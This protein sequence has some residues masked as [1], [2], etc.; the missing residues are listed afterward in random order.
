MTTTYAT[1]P[2]IFAGIDTPFRRVAESRTNLRLPAGLSVVSADG[3]WSI[4][5]D[6]FYE[7]FP[8]RLKDRAPRLMKDETG[9]FDWRI[10]GQSIFPDFLR[11]TFSAFE[12]VDGCTQMDAR[13][14]DLDAEGIDKEIA[15][16]NAIA[17]FYGSPDLE[18]REWVFRI[19]NEHLSEMQA[20]APGRFYGVGLINYWDPTQAKA[21]ID[22]LKSLGLKTFLLPISP[23]GAD[24]E[25]LNY[26][27]PEMDRLWSAIEESGLPVCYHVG[28][29]FQPG[30]GAAGTAA[31][32][33]FAPFRK[34]MGELIFG[35]ILD[36]H[37]GLQ[38]MFAEG[39][40]NWVPGALQ[41]AAMTYECYSDLIEPKIKHHPL[42]YWQKNLYASF[43][44]D[45]VGLEMMHHIGVDRVMWSSDYP[46]PESV[47]GR[48]WTAMEEVLEAVPEAAARK[49]LG[50]TASR[51]FNI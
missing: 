47:F 26:C 9:F 33:N 19:Y 30:P 21:S 8:S 24:M 13:I 46:H 34:T 15:F 25:S 17:F 5:D 12:K 3:H 35:G 4:T 2:H 42:H 50:D 11:D 44:T 18:V 31:M 49:I 32:V 51:V 10:G 37:P 45:P 41:T 40:I 6:I 39:D 43:M 22:E 48:A 14:R 36:R 23:K 7:R 38:V 29:H 27:V 16:G 28:E 20:R 1:K